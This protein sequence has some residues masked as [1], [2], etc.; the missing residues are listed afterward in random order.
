MS[1]GNTILTI[2]KN[3]IITNT[4]KGTTKFTV[5]KWV[6]AA[7]AGSRPDIYLTLHRIDPTLSDNNEKYIMTTL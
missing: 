2:Q 3:V 5:T 6:D 7:S 4:R 1:R